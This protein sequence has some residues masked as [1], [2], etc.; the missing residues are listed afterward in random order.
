[1]S[2]KAVFVWCIMLGVLDGIYCIVC[3]YLPHIQNYMW[4]G[5]ISLPIYFCGGAKLPE[6]P[7]YFCCAASGVFWGGLAL[8][9]LGMD[10]TANAN[11]N[12]ILVVTVVVCIGCFVHLGLLTENVFKGLFSNGPMMFGGF[13]AIFSQGLTE[14]FW[15][16]ITLTMGFRMGYGCYRST[17]YQIS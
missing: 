1:M 9:G 16:L 12:M 3:S 13:A 10:L 17:N 6:L 8:I 15:V 4:I 5:F 7:K 2:K 11:L 14:W